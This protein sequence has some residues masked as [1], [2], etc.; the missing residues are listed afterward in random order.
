MT[1]TFLEK[2]GYILDELLVVRKGIDELRKQNY[3]LPV[4]INGL[5]I[6][7]AL[8]ISTTLLTASPLGFTLIV[9]NTEFVVPKSI[10]THRSLF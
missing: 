2:Y 3:E 7:T 10:P 1:F 6:M 8:G 5:L 4:E 9:A